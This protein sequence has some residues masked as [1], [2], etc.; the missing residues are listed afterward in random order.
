MGRGDG[1]PE[2]GPGR[3]RSCRL[4]GIVDLAGA[5]AWAGALTAGLALLNFYVLLSY[6]EPGGETQDKIVGI[7]VAITTAAAWLVLGAGLIAAGGPDHF[8]VRPLAGPSTRAVLLRA[9]L[10]T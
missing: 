3:R 8:L 7:R 9:F 1:M 6:L 10:P 2:G 4:S 5:G